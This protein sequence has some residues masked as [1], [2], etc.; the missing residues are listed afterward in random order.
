MS[1]LA[2]ARDLIVL[3]GHCPSE[4]AEKLLQRLLAS[5]VATVDLL[6][7]ESLH[8]AVIQVLL[9]A[10]PTIRMPPAETEVGKQLLAQL[11]SV[12]SY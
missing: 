10:A 11:R 6:S 2:P 5:P 3:E 4:D 8:T 7:C 1:V 12:I 9:A